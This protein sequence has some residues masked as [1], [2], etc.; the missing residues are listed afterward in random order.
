MAKVSVFALSDSS[1]SWQLW[2]KCLQFLFWDELLFCMSVWSSLIPFY[3]FGQVMCCLQLQC[4]G[5]V[6]FC[7]NILIICDKHMFVQP[8][9]W[10]GDQVEQGLSQA[11]FGSDGGFTFI[12]PPHFWS[13]LVHRPNSKFMHLVLKRLNDFLSWESLQKSFLQKFLWITLVLLGSQ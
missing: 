5:F 3:S 8:C 10:G 2:I 13:M 4:E 9:F 11:L 6:R 7:K 1:Q 12:T